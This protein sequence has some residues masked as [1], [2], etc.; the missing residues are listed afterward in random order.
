MR[1]VTGGENEMRWV[2]LEVQ[3]DMRTVDQGGCET[4]GH[5]GC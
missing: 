2:T 1:Y 3:I 4:E 5:D